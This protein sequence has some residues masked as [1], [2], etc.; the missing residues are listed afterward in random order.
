MLETENDLIANKNISA[1]EPIQ[2]LALLQYVFTLNTVS[3]R[4]RIAEI[5]YRH[6][7]GH[8][9]VLEAFLTS[10]LPLAHRP[11]ATARE[12]N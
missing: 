12:V 3:V 6:G 8:P 9:R 7:R 5:V 10:T 4:T 2:V 1:L 11:V